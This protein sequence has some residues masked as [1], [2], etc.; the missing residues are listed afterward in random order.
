MYMA[1]QK[2]GRGMC[3]L[4]MTL[5]RDIKVV[6]YNE[7][8]LLQLAQWGLYIIVCV[9]SEYTLSIIYDKNC[10]GGAQS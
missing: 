1:S 7:W 8:E 3:P 4:F 5:C 6:A 9:L 10:T 2:G